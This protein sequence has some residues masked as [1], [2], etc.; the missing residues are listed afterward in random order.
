V[1]RSRRFVHIDSLDGL[2]GLAAAIVLIGH[3][4]VALEKTPE[5]LNAIRHSPLAVLINGYGAVHLFFILSGFCLASSAARC[6]SL[7]ELLQYF[8]RRVF[9][10]HPPYMAA[11]L[12]AWCASF[13]YDASHANG[14]LS[15]WILNYTQVHLSLPEL[16][17]FLTYP[18][19]AA[20]QL[21]AAWSMAVE[22]LFSFL[23][24]AMMWLALRSHW[25][26]LVALC[27]Y[28][29]LSSG[30]QPGI[31][32]Y[33]IYFSIGI[34][35]YQERERLG[36]WFDHFGPVSAGVFILLAL[37][38]FGS[39]VAFALFYKPS[40]P[41]LS[42]IGGT[43][44]V[45]GAIFLPGMRRFLSLRPLVHFG[46]I[47]YSF[48]LLHLTALIVATRMIT[49]PAG[50]GDALLLVGASLVVTTGC[51]EIS[52]RLVE[53]PSIAAGNAICRRVAGWSGASAQLSSLL[54]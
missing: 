24:P 39:P 43:G 37:G 6:G 36:R 45:C 21:P 44:L 28:P 50:I 53:R 12:V 26:V 15:R 17:G 38:F 41:I 49:G 9:R 47:S 3:T 35:I 52:Y 34:A 1:D 29:V 14:G 46:K 40:G 30:F 51:A 13:F 42:V 54:R 25:A 20:N 33:G 7:W 16:L 27:C 48:Y 11:L 19:T 23:L 22:M 31:L 18:G 10:I 32:R 2:R 5:V 4:H 8:I